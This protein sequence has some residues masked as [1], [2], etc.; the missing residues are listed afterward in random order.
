[1]LEIKHVETPVVKWAKKRKIE[2]LKLNVLGQRGF[3]DRIFF[4][5]GGKPFL[6]EFKRRNGKLSKLQERKIKKLRIS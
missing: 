6:I 3:P 2:A 1:M 4:L 5:A